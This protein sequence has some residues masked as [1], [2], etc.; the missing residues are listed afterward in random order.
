[1]K[2]FALYS[3]YYDLLYRDKNYD[4]E[5]NLVR[6]LIEKH[7][8]GA[9][10]ILDMGCGTGRHAVALGRMGYRVLGVDKSLEMIHLAKARLKYRKDEKVLDVGFQQKDIRRLEL[11]ETFDVVIS[12]FHVISYQLSDIDLERTFSSIRKHLRPD[13]V[14]IID[15]WY[16]PAVLKIG[17]SLRVKRCE[18][19]DFKILRIA[20]PRIREDENHVDVQYTMFIRSKQTDQIEEIQEKHTM[21]YF[22]LP[23]IISLLNRNRL[24]VIECR[25]WQTGRPPSDNTWSV[26]ILGRREECV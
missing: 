22:F 10:S 1:M 7:H 17:P 26:Y 25:E 14:F 18:D 21:R 12:L 5:A 15:F 20:E 4:A 24:G 23:E 16:G 11:H 3:Q 19:S 9:S 8:A 2:Q 13:G 6:A